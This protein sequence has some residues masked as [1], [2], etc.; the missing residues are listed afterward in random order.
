MSKK[1][2]ETATATR[3]YCE[4]EPKECDG[5]CCYAKTKKGGK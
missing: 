5:K 1:K 4:V 2:K 3:Q